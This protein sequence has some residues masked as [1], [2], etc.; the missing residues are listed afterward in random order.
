MAILLSNE[1]DI[2]VDEDLIRR[3]AEHALELEGAS[4]EAELSVAFVG[5]DE[6]RR[7]NEEYR[8]V[9]EPTDVL[10]FAMEDEVLTGRDFEEPRLIG[11]VVISP[12]IARLTAQE[13]GH[14]LEAEIGL[15]LVHGILHLLGYNHEKPEEAQQMEAREREL[16]RPFFGG[17]FES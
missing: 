16:L 9:P 17:V 13:M 1:Q 2:P 6:M 4:M 7:L 8:G 14:S 11:D 10:S 12:L 5:V 15:L 3:V